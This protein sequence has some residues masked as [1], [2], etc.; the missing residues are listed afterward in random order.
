M[1]RNRAVALILCWLASPIVCGLG[2]GALHANSGL[3]EPFEGRIEILGATAEDFDTLT[4]GLAGTEH[5]QR[6]DIERASVLFQLQFTI[7]DSAGEQNFITVSSEDPV[8]EPFLNFLLELNWSNGR[9]L[10]EYTVLLDPPIYDPHQ[11]RVEPA[12]GPVVE[13]PLEVP[14]PAPAAAREPT[15]EA[16]D[17][18]SDMATPDVMVPSGEYVTG[19]EVGPMIATDTLWSIS[20]ARRPDESVTVQQMMLAVLRENPDAFSDGNINM[21]RRGAILRLPDQATIGSVAP[22]DA[23]AEV[24]RQNQIWEEYRQQLGLA[25][26]AQPLG[27]PAAGPPP[28]VTPEVQADAR[29]ELLAPGA[30]ESGGAP[31][32][33]GGGADLLREELDAQSQLNVDLE[34][35]L[36]EAE[37][38]I[39]LLQRQVNIKDEELAALQARLAELGI[40]HGDIGAVEVPVEEPPPV[41]PDTVAVVEPEVEPE[42]A[43]EPEPEVLPEPE[44]EIE[45]EPD[46][47]IEE[48]ADFDSVADVPVDEVPVEEPELVDTEPEDIIEMDTGPPAEAGFPANL[49]PEHIASMVP[50]GALTIL[51]IAALVILGLFVG[52]VQFLLKSRAGRSAAPVAAVAAPAVRV[53][54]EEE[55]PEPDDDVTEEPDITSVMKP[56]DV[57]SEA[58]TEVSEDETAEAFDPDSTKEEFDPDATLEADS[59]SEAEPQ[60]D[61]E[62]TVAQAGAIAQAAAVAE[63]EDPLEE[64]N[65]YLAYERF[66]QAEELVKR[67]IGEY[68]DRHEYKLRL[69]EVYYSSN[70]KGAYEASARELNEAV[71]E[72]DP[73]W[74]SAVAM[75]SEMSPERALFE[76]GAE[77]AEA[78]PD[79]EAAKAF[80]DITGDSDESE[81][82]AD[83][84]VMAPGSDADDGL[85]FDL[86][87]ADDTA[88]DEGILDL[89]ATAGDDDEGMLD[90]TAADT[91]TGDAPL[92]VSS[93]GEAD[94][95]LDITDRGSVRGRSARSDRRRYGRD[96]GHHRHG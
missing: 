72:S 34:D 83:T 66:D 9:L 41:E 26:T 79:Q 20:T 95:V 59:E 38:I 60:E 23:F 82:G 58:I 68:P 15:A 89:T 84:M 65:V 91:G 94:G 44:V 57:P 85:D 56:G 75:W 81:A 90:L 2:L 4:I 73:L 52:V 92:D 53:A 76:E 64:V 70:D 45:P 35:K 16:F 80:V 1:L 19:G 18:L 22:G 7:D 13:V 32:S 43:I 27:A 47:A 37:E 49:I 6:A 48:D 74:E 3:N 24:K 30:D 78:A 12:P 87:A 62:A 42:P 25:P 21:L 71:G 17:T 28:D 63:E 61:L 36:T 40:E 5:F 93:V 31:G 46:I 67:V 88:D 69:L 10:R 11:R 51:G 55:E 77:L 50:G 33:A 86:A 14:E 54:A 39:D 8:R 29:L 96:H